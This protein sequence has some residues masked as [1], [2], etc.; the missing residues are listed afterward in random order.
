VSKS[1]KERKSFTIAKDDKL[2]LISTLSPPA[3][4]SSDEVTN[5]LENVTAVPNGHAQTDAHM[6]GYIK[7]I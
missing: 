3:T 7:S 4:P 2:E 1:G 6:N 5:P